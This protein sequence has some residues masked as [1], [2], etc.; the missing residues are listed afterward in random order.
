MDK[1]TT[2]Q[3]SDISVSCIT[4]MLLKNLW[5]ILASAAIFVMLAAMYL[6]FLFVPK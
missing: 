5:M 3:E 6:N 1:H 2:I 4:R